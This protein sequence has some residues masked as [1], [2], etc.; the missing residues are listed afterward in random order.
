MNRLKRIVLFTL[1]GV[2]FLSVPIHFWMTDPQ[3]VMRRAFFLQAPLAKLSQQCSPNSPGW[4]GRMSLAGVDQLKALSTQ[5]A[6]VDKNGGLSHCETGWQSTVL[7]S[8]RVDDN[9]RFR[10]GSLTKPVT[11]SA[12]IILA[13]EGRIDYRDDLV[14]SLNLG[15]TSFV[16]AAFREV[17]VEQLLRHRSGIQGE[18]FLNRKKT[19]C[20]N[21][22]ASFIAEGKIKRAGEFE[23][24]NM[25][26][27]L[28]GEVISNKVGRPYKNAIDQLYGLNQ[29]GILF[30]EYERKGDEVKRDFRFN[31]FYGVNNKGRF[32]YESVAATAGLS[33]SASAYSL[34]L[35]DIIG[36]TNGEILAGF[37]ESCDDSNFKSCYGYGF[38]A[39][40]PPEGRRLLVK[41]GYMPGAS[42][43]VVVNEEREIF[44]WL[45]NSDTENAVSG[46]SMRKFL[47]R[48]GGEGF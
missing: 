3:D 26:Y 41:E 30:V 4:L 14:D 20:P 42:G 32:D 27:C 2:I 8:R 44:V 25:G 29:R 35:K 48:L 10:Y 1:V 36:K 28:L 13:N 21:D 31:D 9:T 22:L 45:G 39:Y 15:I 33:G 38:Y 7:F 16:N 43:V 24:S 18:I 40:T 12:I 47:K 6:F 17:T 46:E 37:D 34:L 5:V 19:A 23:Y 11:A